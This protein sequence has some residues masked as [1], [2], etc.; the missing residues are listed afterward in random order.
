MSTLQWKSQAVLPP[1]QELRNAH[2]SYSKITQDLSIVT[3]R[4]F[5]VVA[6]DDF[7]FNKFMTD[8][9]DR[10][11]NLPCKLYEKHIMCA[12]R[13]ASQHSSYDPTL[14]GTCIF[15]IIEGNDTG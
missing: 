8:I 6:K 1:L 11:R 14:D 12:G 7:E 10:N 15:P 9:M 5:L 13:I 2:V 4:S 3:P